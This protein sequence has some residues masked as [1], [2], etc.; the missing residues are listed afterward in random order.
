MNADNNYVLDSSFE[1][2]EIPK[3]YNFGKKVILLGVII[4]Y[5]QF[6]LIYFD[7]ANEFLNPPG[8][9]ILKW[10]TCKIDTNYRLH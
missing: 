4:I 3:N 8:Y 6:C 10:G 1:N 5:L 9:D 2:E 7:S